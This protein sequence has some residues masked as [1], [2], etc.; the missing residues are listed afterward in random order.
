MENQL[1]IFQEELQELLIKSQLN[2]RKLTINNIQLS[3]LMKTSANDLH[4]AVE[5]NT[6]KVNMQI[7][8]CM[9]MQDEFL[10]I[11][12]LQKKVEIFRLIVEDVQKKKEQEYQ[13]LLKG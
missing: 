12:A 10:Q 8:Q 5:E 13:S 4:Q 11:E 3:D 2:M 7:K 1:K 6:D 9:Q